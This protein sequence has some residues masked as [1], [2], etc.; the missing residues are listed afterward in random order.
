MI[1]GLLTGLD[2]VIGVRAGVVVEWRRAVRTDG[3]GGGSEEGEGPFPA[4]AEDAEEEI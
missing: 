3:G 1:R 4:E 2:G